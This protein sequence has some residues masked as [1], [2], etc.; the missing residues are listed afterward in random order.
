MKYLLILWILNVRGVA[1]Y[2]TVTP[3]TVRSDLPYALCM[4]LG[5][6]A[7]KAGLRVIHFECREV[8]K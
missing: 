4:E 7:V 8:A 2:T 5:R 3:V 6:G 1:A